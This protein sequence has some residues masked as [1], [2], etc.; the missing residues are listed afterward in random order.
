MSKAAVANL[1]KVNESLKEQIAALKQNF[2]DLQRSLQRNQLPADSNGAHSTPSSLDP[3]TS[4]PLQFYSQS[5]DDLNQFRLN[6]NL[7]IDKLWSRLNLLASQVEKIAVTIEEIQRYS[8]QCNI[9]IIGLSETDVNESAS[10]TT[11]LCLSL[12]NAVGIDICSQDID[13]AH[14]I[15]T[16]NAIPDRKPVICKFTRRIA[17][18]QV[19]KRRKNAC[20]VQATAIGLPA[21]SSKELNSLTILYPKSSNSWQMSKSFK[22]EMASLSADQ[23]ISLY[24]FVS[25]TPLAQFRIGK[26]WK[27]L[28]G[29]RDFL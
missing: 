3:E 7:E 10:T 23:R 14:R 29:K 5:Y 9:K 22:T 27:H 25:L 17:K 24:I 11:A 6:A 2:V 20:K 28:P 15:P 18:E 12:F 4:T 13:I 19:M 16:R 21:E 8:Y 1:Q 26:T